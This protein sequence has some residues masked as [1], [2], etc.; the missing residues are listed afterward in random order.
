MDNSKR[1]SGPEPDPRAATTF[2]ELVRG[3]AAVYGDDIALKFTGET[4]ADQTI[5]FA[6][7][8]RQSA[9]MARG[10]IARG[11]GKGTRVGILA[12]NTPL[13]A[14]AFAAICRIGAVAIPIST[15]IKANELVR[16]I[17]QSDISG[18]IC[19]RSLLGH[20]FVTR[21]SEALVELARATGP[22]LRLTET[23][24]LRWIVVSSGDLPP[25][26][27][28]LDWLTEAAPGV[29]E[30][31]L[32]AIEA[33]VHVTDQMVE[34][35]TSGSMALPKGVKHNHG[36]ILFRTH[37]LA[38]VG[39]V[40]AGAEKA[41]GLP[42]FW[43]GG[44]GMYLLPNW[45]RGAISVCTE[46]NRTDSRRALG[47]VLAADD[48][49]QPAEGEIIWSIGMTETWGPYAY[50]DVL[51]VPGYPITAPLDHFSPRYEV[52]LWVD[53]REAMEGE[54]GEI[55]VR[56]YALTPGLHKVENSE[57]FEADGFY[58]TG[59]MGVREGTRIHFLGRDGDMI[60]SASA[61]VSP[62]EVE[63]EMMQLD[64]VHSAYVVGLPD[65][66]RGAIVVAAVIPREGAT[67]DMAAIEAALRK[68]LS[69]FKVPRIYVE[70]DRD[71][72]PMLVTNKVNRRELER[73]L[74][75]QLGREMA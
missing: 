57:Y 51:R 30:D 4:I 50:G 54:R 37:Y 20:D 70:M 43:I 14:I 39:K 41:V 3:A 38:D 52:R 35:Y 33:N 25:G 68:N 19:E 29:S 47:S 13:F 67:L 12:G 32:A 9:E 1:E 74:A 23:P 71:E 58:R 11:V 17:R 8:E 24:F 27:R 21:L 75:R 26:F 42:F 28:N 48:L 18:L 49:R 40:E 16:V 63:M 46:G 45:E 69:G 44:M 61:N 66:E 62:A 5:S 15:L 31:L 59:D 64:G 2:P 60:K 65:K 73:Q 53:G 10:L 7:L 36:P 6:G 22:D 56:G 72:V 34:I 55:Q